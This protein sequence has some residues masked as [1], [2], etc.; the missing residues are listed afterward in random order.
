MNLLI[1][2]ACQSFERF[3]YLS[4]SPRIAPVPQKAGTCHREK[5]TT[6][7]VTFSKPPALPT[8][9]FIFRSYSP[10]SHVST[11]NHYVE[12]LLT[13]R[14]K[15]GWEDHSPRELGNRHHE[16]WCAKFSFD[17]EEPSEKA[18]AQHKYS[19]ENARLNLSNRSPAF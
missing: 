11:K 9:G 2:R 8:W 18:E 12:E 16:P 13:D 7:H 1:A 19:K 3:S 17:L 4:V 14:T 6:C 10:L 5:L 15:H